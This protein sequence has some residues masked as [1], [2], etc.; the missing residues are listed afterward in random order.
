MKAKQVI[1]LYDDYVMGNYTRKPLV[2]AKAKG[3]RVWSSEGKVYLDFFPGWAVSGL[4]HCHKRVVK[5]IQSQAQKLLHV[6]N[7]YYSEPQAKLA[8]KISLNSFGGRVF[9]CNSGAEANESAFKLSRAFGNPKRYEV[10]T[11]LDSFHGR[12]LACTAATGQEKYKRG[13]EPLPEGFKSVPFNNREA[14]LNAVTDKTAAIMLELIQGE[15][16]INVA[17]KAYVRFLRELCFERNMLLI[18]D[19]V[20]TGM[21]RTGKMFCYQHYAVEPD[22]MTLAKSLGGGMPIGAMVVQKKISGILSPGMHASTFGGSPI[23]CAAALAVFEAIEK[24]QLLVNVANM[25]NYLHDEFLR[26]KS[27]HPIIKQIRGVGLMLGLELIVNAP[28]AYDYCLANGLLINCTQ[29]N[30]L[31]IMPA[32]TVTKKEIDEA[33]KILDDAVSKC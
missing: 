5:A 14:V 2:I 19:E 28:R 30:T 21:G 31:R 32:L 20:Q 8:E 12:T 15:G 7:N 27:R 16:G 10:I 24:E 9:F 25:G 22:I 13:F 17:D 3:S 6:S 33:I 11:M 18:F 4:G 29:G 26:L 23:A 1:G